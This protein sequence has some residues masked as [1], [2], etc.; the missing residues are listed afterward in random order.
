MPVG[1]RNF[2]AVSSMSNSVTWLLRALWSHM[3]NSGRP[4]V[5]GNA[6]AGLTSGCQPTG[7][8]TP[9]PAWTARNGSDENLAVACYYLHPGTSI[10]DTIT[11]D[12]P[13]VAAHRLIA[14]VRSVIELNDGREPD[15]PVGLAVDR[16]HWPTS[17]QRP[18]WQL[19]KP[20]HEVERA[21][22]PYDDVRSARHGAWCGSNALQNG[23]EVRHDEYSE[24]APLNRPGATIAYLGRRPGGLSG[25]GGPHDL[26]RPSTAPMR[27]AVNTVARRN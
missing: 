18:A 6:G 23:F 1:G 4:T 26:S 21:G 9:A 3:G 15:A 13:Y 20:R 7:R 5:G 17:V 8:S 14:A 10:A 19:R 12:A 16:A 22:A 11:L 24:N 25:R 27:R 2:G